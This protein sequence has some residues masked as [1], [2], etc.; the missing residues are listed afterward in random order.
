[1]DVRTRMAPSP[2]GEYHIGHI[3]TLLYNYAFARK[4]GGK[5]I[6]R[7]E[8]TDRERYVEGA[9]D[10]IL[11]N[12]KDYGFEWDEGPGIDGPFAPYV[13]SE[14]LNIYKK[15][16][17]GLI[18][19]GHAYYCFCSA[20][21]LE[22]LREEQRKQG[23]PTTKYDKC[24]LGLSGKEVKKN[25]EEGKKFVIRLKVPQD[26]I[27]SFEDAV[28][29][30]VK[31]NSND[32]D[33]QILLKTDGYPTYHLAV[34]IDDHLM[35]ITHVMRGIDWLPSTPK[36]VLLYQ[37]FGWELPV[38]I[39]L[40]NLKELG[41]NKKL[42]KR[43][44]SVAAAEFLQEGYI[45][46]AL[47]NFIMFLGWNPGGEKEIY[48]LEEFIKDFSV[49]R[50]HKTDLVAFDRQKL[51][52]MNGHYIRNMADE[53]LLETLDSWSK[54]FNIELS[55]S[56]KPKE[57]R[58]KVLSL[59]KDRIK[60]LSD[61]N[62]LSGFF[63]ESNIP[64]KDLLVSYT[65][66]GGRA[67]EMLEAFSQVFSGISGDNWTADNIET[68]SHTMLKEKNYTAKEAFMT[69]RIAVTCLS[70][71]PALVAV[72]EL[73]GKEEVLKRIKK[74]LSVLNNG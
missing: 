69:L 1:M 53:K 65:E 33:D 25:L 63:F 34:V 68:L 12:I 45:P 27:I 51:L 11:D 5:F 15:H 19:K 26:E 62:S 72:M 41:G 70:A 18:E 6:I 16:A 31:I 29:G 52:W 9:V 42:S 21:R 67:L 74:A 43:F 22:S 46:E 36:H 8:D 7:I 73:L 24:C 17:H 55:G 60:K 38:Y 28:L 44:G 10:R 40:P 30:E 50:I 56:G 59:I 20:E 54:K 64:E 23:L 3:R 61:F 58:I 35:E 14:R 2:T 13:Q 48:S 49:E 37:Y 66:S 4:N 71:T 47:V 32:L 39:H 57:F